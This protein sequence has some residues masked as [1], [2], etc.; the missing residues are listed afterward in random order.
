MV[1]VGQAWREGA[2]ALLLDVP[3]R[4]YIEL[5]EDVHPSSQSAVC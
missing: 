1:C 3:G 4:Y 2:S 5:T